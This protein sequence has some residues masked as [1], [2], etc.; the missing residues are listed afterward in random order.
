[1]RRRQ[2]LI[3]ICLSTAGACGTTQV[4]AG[5]GP[6]TKPVVGAIPQDAGTV[7]LR[8]S[9]DGITFLIYGALSRTQ[10]TVDSIQ[11]VGSRLASR[12]PDPDGFRVV[13][14]GVTGAVIDTIRLWSPLDHFEWDSAGKHERRVSA[15]AAPVTVLVP[16]RL[17]VASVELQWPGAAGLGRIDVTSALLRFCAGSPQNPGCRLQR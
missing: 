1:M 9:G 17:G 5:P 2:L 4:P 12:S 10:F 13:R 8:S 14:Y 6:G 16:A 15:T 7:S 11:P 3:L